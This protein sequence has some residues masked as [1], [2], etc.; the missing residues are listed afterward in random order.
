M[1][2][3]DADVHEIY[4]AICAS[5]WNLAIVLLEKYTDP[6][7]SRDA[8]HVPDANKPKRATVVA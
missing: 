3:A 4:D 1:F 2:S 6:P 5:D 8:T 7:P